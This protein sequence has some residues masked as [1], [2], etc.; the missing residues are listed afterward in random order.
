MP[1]LIFDPIVVPPWAVLEILLIGLWLAG[2]ELTCMIIRE[3]RRTLTRR[4]AER[5]E[6]F[7][8]R[9]GIR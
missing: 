6:A 3:H 1:V 8:R 5:D 7:D 2:V 4:R 9:W